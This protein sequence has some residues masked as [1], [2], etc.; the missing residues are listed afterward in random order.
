MRSLS[1]F[2]IDKEYIMELPNADSIIRGEVA[3]IK[4]AAKENTI[5]ASQNQK[6]NAY[7][8]PSQSPSVTVTLSQ[9]G[10]RLAREASANEDLN[11]AT[12]KLQLPK[13]SPYEKQLYKDSGGA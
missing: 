3:Q 5:A 8:A 9:E 6:P 10:R 11:N 13:E 2:Q 7:S 12:D 4:P 1:D